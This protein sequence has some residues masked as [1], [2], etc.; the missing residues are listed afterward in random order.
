MTRYIALTRLISPL[1]SLVDEDK[2]S[3]STA[4]DYISILTKQE[5]TDLISA[6][7]ELNVIP[8]KG[9][10]AKIKESSKAGTLTI[11][12][13]EDLLSTEH[14]AAM[15]VVLKQAR[16]TEYF[17]GGADGVDCWAAEIVLTMREKN[18]TLKLHCV[19]PHEGQSN[20]WSSSAQEQYHSI[21]NRADSVRRSGYDK[22]HFSIT[23]FE[24]WDSFTFPSFLGDPV[25][26]R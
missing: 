5:Q 18:S 9:Q 26:C 11:T 24:K 12:V 7:D 20:K 13:I 21:L 25:P 10:L 19:L 17:T 1:L 2:L 16:L 8:V 3:F 23:F 22:S 14:P 4:A 6:M 15:Q